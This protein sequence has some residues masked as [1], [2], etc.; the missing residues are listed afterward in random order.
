M[1]AIMPA[2]CARASEQLSLRLDSELSEFERVLL[3][4]HLARCAN[5]RAFGES[6]TGLTMAIR[7]VP[8]EQPSVSFDV[9]RTRTRVNSFLASSFRV[10]SAA[11]AIFVVAISGFV[12]LRGTGSGIPGVGV[13]LARARAV[14]D[15]HERQFRRLDN[16]GRT[17]GPEVPRGL[18]AAETVA[19]RAATSSNRHEGRR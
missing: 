3:E 4:A 6:I 18:A 17:L 7:T 14:L 12:G 16:F 11:A 15:L 1:R 5:C 19:P 10:G 9:Y 8:A 13:E 2:D